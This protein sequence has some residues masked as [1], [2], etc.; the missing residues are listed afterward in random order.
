MAK[1]ATLQPVQTSYPAS[2]SFLDQIEIQHG[3][4]A[5]LGRFFWLPTRRHVRVASRSRSLA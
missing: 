5:I 2:A 3:P 4:V 1:H